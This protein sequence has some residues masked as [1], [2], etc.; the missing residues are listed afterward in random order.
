MAKAASPAQLID[1]RIRKL[2]ASLED[3]SGLT[4]KATKTRAAKKASYFRR[5]RRIRLEVSQRPPPIELTSR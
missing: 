2:G 4:A 5:K 3:P 1:G